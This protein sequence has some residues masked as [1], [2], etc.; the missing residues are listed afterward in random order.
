MSKSIKEQLE[1][2]WCVEEPVLKP[3]EPRQESPNNINPTQDSL[4]C[5]KGLKREWTGLACDRNY[6]QYGHG[7]SLNAR[8]TKSITTLHTER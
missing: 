5:D 8:H 7:L 2:M 3:T 4:K 1:E 6:L